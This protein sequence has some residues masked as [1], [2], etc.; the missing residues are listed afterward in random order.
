MPKFIDISGQHFGEWEVISYSGESLWRCR[1]SC[2]EIRDVHGKSLRNGSSKSCGHTTNVFKDLT[3][4]TIGEWVVLKY[5][6]DYKWLCRCSCGN[7]SIVN[8]GDLLTGK[9]KDCGHTRSRKIAERNSSG[10]IKLEGKAFGDWTVLRYLGDKQYECKCSCGKIKSV[11]TRDLIEG[12]SKSCGHNNGKDRFI[13]LTGQVFGELTVVKYMGYKAYLCKCS[14]GETTI[15][16]KGNLLNGSVRSCGCKQY[17]R[18][19][20][21]E[22]LNAINCF[23]GTFGELPFLTD[24][25]NALDIHPGNLRKYIVRYDLDKY[26]NKTYNSKQERD[27]YLMFPGGELHNRQILNGQELDIYYADRKIGIEFNGNYWHSSVYK[28]EKYHQIKTIAAAKKGIRLIHIFEHEWNDSTKRAKIIALLNS[29]LSDKSEVVY[30]RNTHTKLVSAIETRTF[31]D[32][33]HLQNYAY[34][35]INIGCYYNEKLIGIMTFGIP[36]FNSDCQY[37]LIR[38]CWQDNIRVVG[39]AEK[40]FNYF[41]TNYRPTSILTYCDISKFTGGVYTKLG[42]KLAKDA[43]T[44]PNYVWVNS[45][46]NTVLPRYK[47]MKSRLVKVGFGKEDQTEDEIMSSRGFLKIHDC[48]NIKFIWK[49][50]GN[51]GVDIN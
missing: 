27:I 49:H 8:R 18:L 45:A 48:G 31:I 23:I 22:I 50:N 3:G 21:S 38:L 37:E 29:V 7:E 10:R 40:L 9:S 13:D 11:H 26:I 16:L 14:C 47:T 17:N 41:I 6:G 2:G 28:D 19:E 34:S 32:N 44:K 4:E 39:G 43:L 20:S 46:N 30:A 5:L 35:D 36:R 33:Y 24:L 25:S 15:I 1:C 51:T 12:T 42:F